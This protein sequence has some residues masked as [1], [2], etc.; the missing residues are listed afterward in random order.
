[1][2]LVFPELEGEGLSPHQVKQVYIWG[3]SEL[4]MW[5][6][7]G[8]TLDYKIKALRQHKSQMGDWDPTEMVT[9]WAKERAEGY[10]MEYAEVFRRMILVKDT[11]GATEEPEPGQD[12]VH[13]RP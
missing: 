11:E 10:G 13:D 7:I 12:E 4:N 6:D 8:Q 2:P 1:M 3:A 5:V 9:R